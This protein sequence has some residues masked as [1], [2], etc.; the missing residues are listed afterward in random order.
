MEH[1]MVVLTSPNTL[2]SEPL[3]L[4]PFQEPLLLMF[5]Q[6]LLIAFLQE[7]ITPSPFQLR[8]LKV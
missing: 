3:V 1:T 5:A 4:T 8:T 6:L 2:L 7:L